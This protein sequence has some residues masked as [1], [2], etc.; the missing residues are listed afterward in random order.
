MW[1]WCGQAWFWRTSPGK[2]EAGA[3]W[4]EPGLGVWER[5]FRWGSGK[6]RFEG[7]KSPWFPRDPPRCWFFTTSLCY[8]RAVLQKSW[9]VK[10]ELSW[11]INQ[12]HQ[13]TQNSFSLPRNSLVFFPWIIP[14]IAKNLAFLIFKMHFVNVYQ[15][16]IVFESVIFFYFSFCDVF[17][18]VYFH[19]PWEWVGGQHFYTGLGELWGLSSPLTPIYFLIGPLGSPR[20]FCFYWHPMCSYV[21]R[22][23]D[24][25]LGSTSEREQELRLRLGTLEVLVFPRTPLAF[26]LQPTYIYIFPVWVVSPVFLPFMTNVSFLLWLPN[27]YPSTCVCLW[28]PSQYSQTCMSVTP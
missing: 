3:E 12:K 7:R 22:C 1:R 20:Q 13:N 6:W 24:V 28:L 27:R 18:L 23:I 14:Q 21:I 16:F 8:C 5:G 4:Q 11:W 19:C 15:F 2:T 25:N 26:V 17:L 10:Y 9:I